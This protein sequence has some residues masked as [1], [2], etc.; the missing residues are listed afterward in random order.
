MA[1]RNDAPFRHCRGNNIRKLASR[2]PDKHVKISRV[3]ILTEN[4]SKAPYG[5]FLSRRNCYLFV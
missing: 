5:Q 4:L 1:R 2:I 3:D